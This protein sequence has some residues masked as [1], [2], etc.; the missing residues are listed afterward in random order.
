MTPPKPPV[1][2][3]VDIPF[4]NSIKLTTTINP[5]IQRHSIQ[6][7]LCGVTIDLDISA[8]SSNIHKHRDHE[9][10]RR[11][12]HKLGT[13]RAREHIQVCMLDPS[14]MCFNADDS[15]LIRQVWVHQRMVNWLIKHIYL[16]RQYVY[17]VLL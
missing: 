17:Q 10:C 5:L 9:P 4:E 8:S 12:A 15:L 2:D 6:C 13:Q 16:S 3:P 14:W 1:Q 11:T 7:D